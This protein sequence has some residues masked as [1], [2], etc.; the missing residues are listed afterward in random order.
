[1]GVH[2]I[3][4][5]GT[6]LYEP[7]VYHFPGRERGT[8][9][10]EF[11]QL[12]MLEEFKDQ[13]AE[14][15][16]VSI[17]LTAKAKEWNWDGRSYGGR[18]VQIAGSW[19]SARKQD[20]IEG[21]DKQGMKA[22]L[23]REYPQLWARTAGIDISNASTEEEIWSVF[24]TI[25]NTIDENDEIIFDITHSFR[26]IPMLAITIINYAKALKNCTLKGIYYG[27]YEAGESE[28]GVKY[29]PVVDLTI[30]NE[31]LEWTNAAE[32]FVRY[33]F[34]SKMREV[35]GQK[36]NKIPANERKEWGEIGKKIKAMEKMSSA[37]FTCRGT[38]ASKLGSCK[39]RPDGSK[40]V[41]N[42]YQD[43]MGENE[44]GIKAEVKE[45]AK[46]IKP[47][48]PL[49]E[50]IENE[51]KQYFS[52]RSNVEIGCGVVDW[53]I[54]NHMVQQGYTALEETVITYLCEQYGLDDR[55][56]KT[57]E[58][59]VGK[60]MTGII[61]YVERYKSGTCF[62]ENREKAA[63]E[64]YRL[65]PGNGK[66]G[67]DEEERKEA[68]KKIVM[69]IPVPWAKLCDKIKQKR[70]DINHFGFRDRPAS[71]EELIRDLKTL[72]AE[73]ISLMK[74]PIHM[75]A[76]EGKFPANIPQGENEG[77]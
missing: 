19:T 57:R 70:N 36:M 69:T 6:S 32:A 38:D 3:S 7:V 74:E 51:Y 15:G 39:Y 14:D 16:K 33:G 5:L 77:I 50:K 21:H 72:N 34:A 42:A 1:M 45:K 24:E 75:S 13:I 76:Y 9:E 55:T 23:E 68:I 2:F 59:V 22:I 10:Q 65:L 43:L 44:E 8:K 54:E 40:S 31:I 62:D 58:Y 46:E 29:A 41:K 11:V 73:F 37:I 56:V 35:Y 52:G 28:E 18:D 47:L 63:E 60:A 25:Y 30:Y 20:V 4:V 61:K 64:I 53:S 17:F 26:S 66:D 49:I 67:P 12:A 71:S 27:A 48:Y